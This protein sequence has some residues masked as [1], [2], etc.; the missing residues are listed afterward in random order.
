MRRSR[1]FD[2]APLGWGDAVTAFER[3]A[4]GL[5][6]VVADLVGDPGNAVV[7]TREKVLGDLHAPV[8]E[9]AD[10]R[11]T[12]VLA[13]VYIADD[14]ATIA[15]HAAA[16]PFPCDAAQRVRTILDPTSGIRFGPRWTSPAG[17]PSNESV[18][19]TPIGPAVA[20]QPLWWRLSHPFDAGHAGRSV[21]RLIEWSPPP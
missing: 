16:G 9:V 11:A 18:A 5:F 4:E 3:P 7:G 2:G 17:T 20:R 10:R 14:E 8:R 1:E 21:N 12:E 15:E 19:H 13:C 6:G